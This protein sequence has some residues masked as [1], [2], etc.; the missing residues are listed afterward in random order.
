M[1]M[2]DEQLTDAGAD[3]V[4]ATPTPIASGDGSRAGLSRQSALAVLAIVLLLGG[5]AVVALTLASP[6]NRGLFPNLPTF[7]PLAA[8]ITSEAELI[9]FAELNADPAAFRDRRIQVSGVYTPVEVPDCRP[10]AGPVVRW[11]LVDEELQLNAI[12]FE[13]VLPLLDDGTEMTIAGIWRVY[14]GP[15][16][17]GKEPADDELWYLAVDQ[18]LEPN[19][20]FGAGGSSL[21]VVAGSPQP[22]LPPLDLALPTPAATTALTATET[23]PPTA[24]LAPTLPFGLTM[25]STP[26]IPVSGTPSP[27]VTVGAT[28]TLGTPAGT[29]TPTLTVTPGPSPTPSPTLSGSETAT[30]EIPT[31]TT[32]GPGYPIPP[33]STT[34]GYPPP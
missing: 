31:A 19:P 33:T 27:T 32:E 24:S 34:E 6:G 23:L 9:G 21:T 29:G 5:L 22:T 2:P 28:G 11:S 16:G 18:I 15:L 26:T 14:Q 1:N 13:N 12:G 17:C 4:Q 10:F 3:P 8:E 20:L 30:L 7:T 25:T